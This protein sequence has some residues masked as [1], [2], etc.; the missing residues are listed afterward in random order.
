MCRYFATK[1]SDL[2]HVRTSEAGFTLVEG[3]VASL[4]SVI[5]AG[6]LFAILR[7]N[8]DGVKDG[9]VNAKVQFQYETAMAEIAKS[10]RQAAA[11]LDGVTGEAYPPA[12]TFTEIS[13]S[14]IVMFDG[15][16]NKFRGFWV[17][18]GALYECSA[19]FTLADYTLFKVGN[20][21]TLNVP[22]A[23]PFQLSSDRLTL[24][25]SMSVTGTFSGIT[26][27]APSRGEVFACRNY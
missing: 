18:G 13:T 22:D 26:A 14:K 8:N 16:G 10:A 5:L 9:A 1:Y 17:K 11:V 12:G 24:T 2:K 23:N 19:G 27:V 7:M 3:V 21:S 15:N 4:L 6:V 20:W 25:T